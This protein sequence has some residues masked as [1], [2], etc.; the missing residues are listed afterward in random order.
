MNNQTLGELKACFTIS[1]RTRIF[2]VAS[3]QV[4]DKAFCSQ[5][6]YQSDERI[7]MPEQGREYADYAQSIFNKIE[8]LV[9]AVIL[10]RLMDMHSAVDASF[11]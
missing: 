5:C 1:R 11:P 8:A 9:K 4:R 3:S 10:R 2:L 7:T 6:G